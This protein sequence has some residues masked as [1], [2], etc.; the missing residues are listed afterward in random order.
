MAITEHCQTEEAMASFP[1][2]NYVL[3]V[4]YWLYC[5]KK[6]NA[7]GRDALYIKR[8]TGETAREDINFI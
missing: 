6:A 2:E 7:H 1:Q 8:S 5:R 3:V 4:G